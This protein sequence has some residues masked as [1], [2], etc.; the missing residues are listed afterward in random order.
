MEFTT[1]EEG[2]TKNISR[3]EEFENKRPTLNNNSIPGAWGD[4][5]LIHTPKDLRAEKFEP[6]TRGPVMY[7]GPNLQTKDAH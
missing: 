1:V 4:C 2:S 7:I 6:H 5:F 3:I